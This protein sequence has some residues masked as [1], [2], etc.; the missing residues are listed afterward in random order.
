MRAAHQLV[1]VGERAEARV[2]AL[3]VGYVVPEVGHR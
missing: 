2:D 3:V 1:E